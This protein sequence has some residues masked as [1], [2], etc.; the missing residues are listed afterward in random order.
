V[1]IGLESA[2]GLAAAHQQGLIHRDVKP[3]NL[4]LETLQGEPGVSP[5]GIRVKVLDFGLAH[6]IEAENTLT[7]SGVVMG[8]PAY[9]APEQAAA[10][11]VDAR[12]DLFG[13]GCV[14]YE[15]VTGQR[16]FVGSTTLAVL[17]QLAVHHP[18]APIQLRQEVLPALSNLI[19]QLLAKD[20]EQRPGSARAVI[21]A[22]R[23][24][25]AG[26]PL[27]EADRASRPAT[28][29]P[30][31]P[32]APPDRPLS[33]ATLPSRS[34]ASGRRRQ[35]LV[36][37]AA[38]FLL[39]GGALWYGLTKPAPERSGGGPPLDGE[40][41]VRVWNKDKSKRGGKIGV[42]AEVLPVRMYDLLHMEARLNQPA[43][44]YMLWVDGKGVVTPLYPWNPEEDIV[45]RTLP[46]KPPPQTPRA[47]VHNPSRSGKG[48]NAD[49]TA[50]LDTILLLAR[51]M[52]LPEDMRL[53][54][55]LGKVPE[56]PL[57]PLGEV[58]V[59]GL[60][61]GRPAEEAKLDRNRAPLD[62]AQV[63][64]DQL[65]QLLD[66]LRDHFEL[67]RAVQFAHVGK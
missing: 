6:V 1:R 34:S 16:P 48:W 61:G 17:Q 37:L 56:A 21:V 46:P 59:R 65:V 20:R 35:V 29:P 25:L 50:G 40:L 14:L 64:D 58:V 4:W 18:P 15:A 54:E 8:T 32:N 41:I 31:P 67:I 47:E 11:P 7:G 44:V 30:S 39:G 22:L 13:L 10:Q 60:N 53:A 42:D 38:L 49:N 33:E 27:P 23:A 63:I 5:T 2:E 36:G 57:G 19:E 66:R 9:M 62:Q 52:P 12:A 51:K 43:Y 24:L 45:Y 55:V 26:Q 28:F 3:G